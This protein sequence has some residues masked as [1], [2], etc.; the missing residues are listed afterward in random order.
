MRLISQLLG[1]VTFLIGCGLFI[2]AA[3]LPTNYSLGG[4]SAMQ[5][6]QV[7]D[8]ATYY[9]VLAIAAFAGTLVLATASRGD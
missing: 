9:A 1:A 3:Y 6:S 5:I 7:Y 4:A 2:Y 8:T